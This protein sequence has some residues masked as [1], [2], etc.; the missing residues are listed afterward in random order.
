M[1]LFFNNEKRNMTYDDLN[2]F[3]WST[4]TGIAVTDGEFKESTYFKCIKR[5]AEDVAKVPVILKQRTVDGDVRAEENYLYDLIKFRPNPYMS[6]VDFFKAIEATRQ[7]K[8]EAFA[9]IT[10]KA[11]KI[12]GLYPINVTKLLIDNIGL[13]K[14]KKNNAILVYYTC[15]SDLKEY[16]CAYDDI[17]HFKG[18]TLDGISSISVKDN[19]KQT[20]N[21][22]AYA[23]SYQADLFAS[24]L[25]NKA[26]VQFMSDIKDEK[27][28]KEAQAMF[29]RMYTSS[30]RILTVP[31]GYQVSPLQLNLSDSQFAELK[32][33][34]QV[35]ICTSFG[36]PPH[37]I[38]I[39]DGYNNNSLEQ[40]NLSY[41]VNTLLILFEGNELE[42]SYKLLTET[43]RKKGFFF[44]AN[45]NVLLRVSAKEQAE[46]LNSYIQNSV[47]APN[48]VRRILGEVKKEDGDD[49]LA[50]SGTLKIKD[51]YNTAKDNAGGGAK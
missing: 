48:E 1:G 23:Q 6:S 29:D 10:R 12:T 2:K 3:S 50:S 8:G 17:L 19:L 36:V 14:T 21:T 15:S 22:N 5:L 47:Y 51:L 40:S 37:L 28:L 49:L 34:G 33:M 25:T 32:K 31:A 24:G 39:M 45:Q 13:A 35:D 43:D 26:V 18:M 4:G 46:I 30:K 27:K 44:E 9:L 41:L 20:I 42:L 38:G 16:T 7:H 11:N